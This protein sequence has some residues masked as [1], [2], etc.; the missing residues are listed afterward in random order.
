MNIRLGALAAA[1][2]AVVLLPWVLYLARPASIGQLA[3]LAAFGVFQMAVPYLLLVRGLR[4]ISSQEAVAI[5]MLEPILL[6]IWAFLVRGEVPALSTAVGA[7]LILAGLAIRYVVL[8]LRT[9]MPAGPDR[10]E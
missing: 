6:P 1:A 5:G 10:G 8:E 2:A 9:P 3:M 4:A 7:S